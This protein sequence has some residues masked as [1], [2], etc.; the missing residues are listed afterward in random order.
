VKNGQAF[1]IPTGY[2]RKDRVLYIHG[3][4]A[5]RML[6]E[7]GNGIPLCVTVTLVDGL[8]LA[9]SAFHSSVNYRSVVILGAAEPVPA[10]DKRAA[11]KIISDHIVPGRWDSL[12]PVKQAE[13]E[14][15]MVLQLDIVEA[16]AKLRTGPPADD[17]E[18][19]ALPIWAGTLELAAPVVTPQP[20]PRLPDGIAV[21]AHVSRYRRI[22]S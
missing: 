15:T 4:A 11:L 7:A 13:I 17:E 21:P 18:D 8:V 3:S 2:G 1:V 10:A 6:N 16:S 20:D 22:K 9:R 12:R 19:Y 5:S 14:Q